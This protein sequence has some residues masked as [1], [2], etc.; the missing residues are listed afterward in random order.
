M[1]FLAAFSVSLFLSLALFAQ[2]G[3]VLNGKL[4][5]YPDDIDI[6]LY[7]N[8]DNAELASG[9]LKAGKFQLK[10]KLDE[11]VLTFL[12]IGTDKPVEV[13]MENAAVT[14]KINKAQPGEVKVEGSKSHLAFKEF[15]GAFLPLVQEVSSLAGTINNMMP[16]GG[17]DSL[18]AIYNARKEAL[19]PVISDFVT[20]NPASPVSIFV[21]EVTYGFNEDVVKLEDRFNSLKPALRNSAA[22]QRLQGFIADSKIGAVGTDA[23]DFTQPDT[24]GIPVSLSSFRGK[25]VLLD[26]WASW[27]GPCRQENPVV[28][29]NFNYFKDKNFTVLGVSLDRPGQK[30]KWLEAIHA[31]NLTWTHVSDLQ[32]WNNAAAKL[33]KVQGIPQNYLL[34]PNGK[35]IARNLR[36]EALRQKLCEV[37]GCN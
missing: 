18:L 9:K 13:F 37:L 26:F 28:V 20:K 25:Y 12:A 19:Q 2:K 32:F 24:L 6:K 23:L 11:P 34:D 33:Y 17:R 5:G 22:G 3:F 27:C 16:G 7:R 8:G 21:L 31:D 30:E 29:E 35:I 15:L 36:G 14:V 4:D 10:G 1:K